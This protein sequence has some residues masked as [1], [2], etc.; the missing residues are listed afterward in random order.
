M[1]INKEY[2]VRMYKS[3]S[4]SNNS[5]D[6]Y[7]FYPITDSKDVITKN[8]LRNISIPS[9]RLSDIL[10]NLGDLAFKDR[11]ETASIHNKG[12]VQLSNDIGS[13]SEHTAPTSKLLHDVYLEA[14]G[15]VSSVTEGNVD[16][17]ILVNGNSVVKVHGLKS[18]AFSETTDYAT[19]EQGLL[20]ESAL[21]RSGGRL[22][23]HVYT[24]V[25]PELYNEL[26][27]KKYVDDEIS[28]LEREQASGIIYGGMIVSEDEIPTANVKT[29]LEFIIGEEGRYCEY[30]CLVGDILIANITSTFVE[31]T[32]D[33]WDRVP[34]G[35]ESETFL[36]ITNTGEASNLTNEFKTGQIIL[37]GAAA[38]N[39]IDVVSKLDLT[40]DLVSARGLINFIISLNLASIDDL[41]RVK[42]AN[43]TT[44]RRGYVNLTPED[45]GAAT[46]AQGEIADHAILG[47]RVGEVHTAEPDT[48]AQVI[49]NTD[50][51]TKIST[52]DFVIPRGQVGIMGPT[53]EEGPI[54]PVG[55]TGPQGV[56]GP[57]GPTG[58]RGED[59]YDGPVGPTG[60][61]GEMGPTGPRGYAGEIGPT[62][63]MGPTG[64]TGPEGPIGPTGANGADGIDGIRGNLI[65][66]GTAISGEPMSPTIFPE[67]GLSESLVGDMYINTETMVVYKCVSGGTSSIATWIYIGRLS[68]GSS[69]PIIPEGGEVPSSGSY[70]EL[71]SDD[72]NP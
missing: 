25:E 61:R 2:H 7:P 56:A 1:S 44:Y 40:N 23:G 70:Y 19:A 65:S 53:G 69:T 29:G 71:V 15:G 8:R 11:E 10:S 32:R 59:G 9:D 39:V 35:N 12:I 6:L 60:S 13:I 48:E 36:R 21:Q 3:L 62:G 43:E 50:P 4:D 45:I 28:R 54:G 68:S 31:R 42:G 41:T 55:P 26:V 52:L 47:I 30:D 33:N 72:D 24:D 17:A 34:S 46:A 63:V 66:W 51:I 64:E 22:D 37:G 67:S 20:A 16:G 38:R 5:K 58:A 57:V 49:I 18:A 14:V 27:N